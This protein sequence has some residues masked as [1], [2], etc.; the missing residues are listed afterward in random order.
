MQMRMV[1][2]MAMAMVMAIAVAALGL[3]HIAGFSIATGMADSSATE[4]AVRAAHSG[5]VGET[6]ILERVTALE[7]AVRAEREARQ[8]LEDELVA[9]YEVLDGLEQQRGAAVTAVGGTEAPG[10]RRVVRDMAAELRDDEARRRQALTDAGFSESRADWLMRRESELRMQAM[11]VRY[12]AMRSDE[13]WNFGTWSSVQDS[14]RAEI[15][16]AEYEM[17]LEAANRPTSVAVA[18]VL[19]ASPALTAGL[20]RGDRITHYDG[21]RVYSIQDLRRAQ[22]DGEPGQ[23]VVVNFERDG[24]PMQVMLPRGPLGI[25]GG[26]AR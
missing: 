13:E 6:G 14:L 8:L 3:S 5:P 12:E 20:Q 15:G 26:R 9:V 22:M 17:Y 23:N 2:A 18:S 7:N 4:R 10:S 21:E 25:S 19:Q 24:T 16:D 11:Q 1:M